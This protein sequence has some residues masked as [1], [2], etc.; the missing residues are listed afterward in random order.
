MTSHLLL[1]LALQV[2]PFYEEVEIWLSPFYTGTP[3]DFTL[4]MSVVS[5]STTENSGLTK[6][7]GMSLD[8]DFNLEG[9][10]MFTVAITASVGADLGATTGAT[11]TVQDND[12]E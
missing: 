10:E 2:S 8:E 1:L 7:F 6:C 4:S 11:V 5:F 12:G 9:N 3:D